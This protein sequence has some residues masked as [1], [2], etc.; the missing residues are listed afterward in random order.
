MIIHC[1]YLFTS[2]IQSISQN[3]LRKLPHNSPHKSRSRCLWGPRSQSHMHGLRFLVDCKFFWVHP[4]LWAPNFT[5]IVVTFPQA[6]TTQIVDPGWSHSWLVPHVWTKL[7]PA[8]SS[9]FIKEQGVLQVHDEPHDN[10]T[11]NWSYVCRWLACGWILGNRVARMM[12]T[13]TLN[14]THGPMDDKISGFL[15]SSAHCP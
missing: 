8:D 6:Q 3:S 1:L 10:H 12:D 14:D 2:R 11:T 7:W 15:S 4:K 9:A 5:K 13:L